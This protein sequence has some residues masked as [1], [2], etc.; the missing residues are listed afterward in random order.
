MSDRIMFDNL[1]FSP[2]VVG[3]VRAKA[4]ISPHISDVV[5]MHVVVKV[6]VFSL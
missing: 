6:G 1:F 3:F 4:S 5:V 2:F